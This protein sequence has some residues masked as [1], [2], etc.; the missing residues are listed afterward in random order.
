MPDETPTDRALKLFAVEGTRFRR[1]GTAD[2]DELTTLVDELP[3][4]PLRVDLE[5]WLAL[6]QAQRRWSL[7]QGDWLAPLEAERSRSERQPLPVGHRVRIWVGRFAPVLIFG[8]GSLV[9]GSFAVRDVGGAAIRPEYEQ[10]TYAIRG[11]LP[12]LDDQAL[13]RTLPDLERALSSATRAIEAPLDE[14]AFDD[15]VS[16][17]LPT[18][19][20]TTGAIDV[21]K[22]SDAASH[23]VWEIELLLGA[24]RPASAIL[25]FDGPSGPRYL[26]DID[27]AVF[28]AVRAASGL[29]PVSVN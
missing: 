15:I 4:S 3:S 24:G 21:A 9:L 5:S 18:L 11:D 2:I 17:G 28:D 6:V 8:V 12:G 29:P 7:G 22:P 14:A 13:V 23:R 20:W 25:T 1:S 26:Y 10:T 19:L 16:K 27:P